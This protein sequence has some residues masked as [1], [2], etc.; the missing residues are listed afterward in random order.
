MHMLQF[1]NKIYQNIS[2]SGSELAKQSITKMI[3][4]QS[5]SENGKFW[6][7][8]EHWDAP[9]FL[10]SSEADGDTAD[11]MLSRLDSPNVKGMLNIK[12]S[13]KT[14]ESHAWVVK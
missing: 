1:N 2:E 4:R 6:Q 13:L 14:L 11:T 9:D 10:L 5:E 3:E 12:P 7:K 8:R